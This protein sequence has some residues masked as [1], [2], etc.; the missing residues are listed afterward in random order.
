MQGI[1][2]EVS[3]NT[4]KTIVK[5]SNDMVNASRPLP[6][7][8]SGRRTR[9]NGMNRCELSSEITP[10]V[11]EG[12]SSHRVLNQWMWASA[13]LPRAYAAY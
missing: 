2:V 10:A 13:H 1:G 9:M 3:R 8:T 12:V 11:A 5:E 6:P 4:K 7:S